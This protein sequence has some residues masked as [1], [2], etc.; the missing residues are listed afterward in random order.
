MSFIIIMKNYFEIINDKKTSFKEKLKLT[1]NFDDILFMEKP[2]EK[3][4]KLEKEDDFMLY[5]LL[6]NKYD[7]ITFE[8]LNI[9]YRKTL[10]FDILKINNNIINIAGINIFPIAKGFDANKFL[11]STVFQGG[12][13]YF[14][15]AL[16]P[17]F[18]TLIDKTICII[19]IIGPHEINE[20]EELELYVHEE[21]FLKNKNKVK[22]IFTYISWNSTKTYKKIINDNGFEYIVVHTPND[23]KISK[24][25]KDCDVVIID[26]VSILNHYDCADDNSVLIHTLFLVN[27]FI[28][29]CKDNSDL[30]FLYTVP[31]I[32]PYYQ[33]FY[34]LYRN[35][36]KLSYYK[37]ILSEF[38]DGIFVFKTFENKKDNL[39]DN[40]INKY[41]QKDDSYSYNLFISIEKPWCNQQGFK[42]AK[43]TDI[44]ISSLYGNI[45]SNN[46]NEF[47]NEIIKNKKKIDKININKIEYLKNYIYYKD[48][49]NYKKIK[50]IILYNI[51]ESIKLLESYNIETNDVYK[52]NTIINPVKLLKSYFNNVDDYKLSKIQFSR[53][54]IYSIS[55][56]DSAQQTSLLIKNNFPNIKIIIDACSNI[57][58]NTYNFSL[59]FSKVICNEL[60]AT[61]YNNLKNNIKVLNLKNVESYNCD[62]IELL[63]KRELLNKIKNNKQSYLLYLDPPWTGVYYK[64]EKNIDLYFGT[65]N[66]CDFIKNIDAIDYICIK[67]PKNFNFSY[68]FYLFDNIRIFKVIFCYIILI[69]KTNN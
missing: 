67:V 59:N 10:N 39:L 2:P 58:G 47:I 42:P 15:I 12:L 3:L 50:S 19:K 8:I 27:Q 56:Y 14:T 1:N 48:S 13:K 21:L 52:K 25:I 30:V 17:Y 61:T 49:F 37:S 7:L 53:D 36:N 65:T 51:D 62:I 23:K 57:G 33:L 43:P 4:V 11:L 64:L 24:F 5:K 69:D 55:S 32:F 63:N 35:F 54:S 29:N 44:M 31:H 46:F 16:N 28:I 66:I 68:L 6:I 41:T 22:I 45:F 40:I 38:R 34:Y 20:K 9:I 26:K 18:N 60:S